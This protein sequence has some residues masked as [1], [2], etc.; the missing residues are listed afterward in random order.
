MRYNNLLDD[1]ELLIADNTLSTERQSEQKLV[2]SKVM[3]SNGGIQSG[4]IMV[5]QPPLNL[6]NPTNL[7]G[8]S[9][10]DLGRHGNVSA[11]HDDSDEV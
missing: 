10:S 4:D 9:S 3:P 8:I 11:Y 2:S 5:I 1:D 7:S 6:P